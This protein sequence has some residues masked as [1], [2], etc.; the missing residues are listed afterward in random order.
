MRRTR[1]CHEE[2]RVG[3]ALLSIHAILHFVQDNDRGSTPDIERAPGNQ[4]SLELRAIKRTPLHY[5]VN[6]KQAGITFSRFTPGIANVRR[7]WLGETPKR[8]PNIRLK[9]AWL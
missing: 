6:R 1:V 5:Q 7:Y 2:S 9:V 4:L 3:H 8:S